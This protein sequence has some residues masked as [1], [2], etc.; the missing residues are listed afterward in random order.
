MLMEI[1][2]RDNVSVDPSE[3]GKYSGVG[4]LSDIRTPACV[5]WPRSVE[6]VKEVVEF[7]NKKSVPL[8][9]VSS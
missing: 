1:V 9:P 7:A 6:Q 2:G 5:V 3:L 8:V 4:T